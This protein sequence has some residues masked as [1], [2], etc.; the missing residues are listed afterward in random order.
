MLGAESQTAFAA[1]SVVAVMDQF[2][3]QLSNKILDHAHCPSRSCH[4]S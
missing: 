4:R 3:V 1:N 2:I